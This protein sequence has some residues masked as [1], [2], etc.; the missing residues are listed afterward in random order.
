MG[1]VQVQNQGMREMQFDW[2]QK[3]RMSCVYI[4]RWRLMILAE[5]F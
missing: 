1:C 3:A 4:Y 5:K 2:L